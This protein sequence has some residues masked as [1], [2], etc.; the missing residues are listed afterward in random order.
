MV[1]ELAHSHRHTQYQPPIVTER[2]CT[3]S[4]QRM[5]YSVNIPFVLRPHIDNNKT[6][7]F[8]CEAFLWPTN[9]CVCVQMCDGRHTGTACDDAKISY[10]P[11]T[12]A[13]HTSYAT[14]NT[15]LWQHC[16]R[17]ALYPVFRNDCNF[18]W[19]K[20]SISFLF[21]KEIF[22]DSKKCFTIVI[23]ARASVLLYYEDRKH[24]LNFSNWHKWNEREPYEWINFADKMKSFQSDFSESLKLP[25]HSLFRSSFTLLQVSR[26]L[27]FP[28]FSCG[29]HRRIVQKKKT[30]KK[31]RKRSAWI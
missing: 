25:L 23:G 16:V 30:K 7:L 28:F 15:I 6:R 26:E 10:F 12:K 3:R 8:V 2:V 5:Q 27:Q 19:G 29:R 20:I 22:V 14:R 17:H 21:C 9:G 24:T 31:K 18:V 13:P 1:V 4:S 11:S